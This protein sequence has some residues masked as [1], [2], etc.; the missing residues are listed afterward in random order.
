M[1]KK[2]NMIIV[3]FFLILTIHGGYLFSLYLPVM[4]FYLFKDKRNMYYIYP[5]SLL[6]ILLFSK[7]SQIGVLNQIGRDRYIK[8]PKVNTNARGVEISREALLLLEKCQDTRCIDIKF[9]REKID[10]REVYTKWLDAWRE[11]Y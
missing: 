10:Y 9:T 3:A 8:L 7:E 5:V 4:L 6:S 2:M 11:D 1:L